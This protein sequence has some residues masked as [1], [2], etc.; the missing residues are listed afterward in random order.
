MQ[1]AALHWVTLLRGVMNHQGTLTMVM[2]I[3]TLRRLWPPLRGSHGLSA[4]GTK[5]GVKQAQR[6]TN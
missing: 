5:D 3:I 2:I 1:T 6:A 4:I